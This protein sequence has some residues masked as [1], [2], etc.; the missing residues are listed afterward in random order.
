MLLLPTRCLQVIWCVLCQRWHFQC[1][2]LPISCI[3]V[4]IGLSG[5]DANYRAPVLRLQS[6][7]LKYK[8]LSIIRAPNCTCNN[9][10]T[11]PLILGLNWTLLGKLIM[12]GVTFL[13]RC[14]PSL[15]RVKRFLESLTVNMV[16]ALTSC[17]VYIQSENRYTNFFPHWWA[18]VIS[19]CTGCLLDCIPRGLSELLI[20]IEHFLGALSTPRRPSRVPGWFFPHGRWRLRLFESASTTPVSY[21]HLTLPTKRIV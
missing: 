14:L 5:G 10:G 3:P 4:L 16:A 19:V 12:I 1:R 15:D 17:K 11:V 8:Y 13:L 9:V 20:A 18:S 2:W 6:F 7:D 21:T